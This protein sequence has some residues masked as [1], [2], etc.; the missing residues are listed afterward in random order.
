MIKRFHVHVA[1][2][3]LDASI[4]FYSTVFGMSPTVLKPDY[5][6]WMMDDPRINFAV[7][8]RGLQPGIDHLGIQV[9]S[10]K[11]LASLREQVSAAEISAFEQTDTVC[12]YARSDKY[13]IADPQGT[14]W[15]TFHT[16]DSAPVYGDG[17]R[18]PQTVCCSTM[19]NASESA[20]SNTCCP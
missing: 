1:V 5:A 6:K 2:N 13:W 7:S 20:N 16:L 15:E 9:E 3:D 12:C 10:E 4:R 18:T 11:E 17:S 8:K 14:A 19:P